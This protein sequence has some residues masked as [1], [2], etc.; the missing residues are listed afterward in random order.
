MPILSTFTILFFLFLINIRC[1]V[2]VKSRAYSTN[3]NNYVNFLIGEWEERISRSRNM[4]EV[5][6]TRE[7]KRKKHFLLWQEEN[8]TCI[9][10]FIFTFTLM[11]F[12]IFV[13][14]Y[15]PVSRV[16]NWHPYTCNLKYSY[17]VQ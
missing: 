17:S 6:G 10:F 15:L 11:S 3:L 9:Q 12:F 16:K 5:L 8:P 1:G 2:D 13:F 14:L 4:L 7:G